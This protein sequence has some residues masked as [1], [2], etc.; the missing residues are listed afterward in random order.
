MM[1]LVRLSADRFDAGAL[2]D[3]LATTG[4]G[5]VASFI[6]HV[7][8]GGD[9]GHDLVALELQHYPGKTEATLEALADEIFARWQLTG[10]ALHHRI[11]RIAVSEPIVFVGAAAAHRA[12]ALEAVDFA[13][14]AVKQGAFLWKKEHRRDQSTAWVEA[15]A[16][17]TERA[18]RW[19]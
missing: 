15:R 18:G 11:G 4:A 13:M 14:D 5:A 17:D 6:G 19:Q 10:F 8:G 2:L 16:S 12:A 7:R 1:R 9:N 3:E